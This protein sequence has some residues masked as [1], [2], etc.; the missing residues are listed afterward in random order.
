MRR[1]TSVQTIEHADGGSH[2]QVYCF[3]HLCGSAYFKKG[4]KN[5]EENLG[6]VKR[7]AEYENP[8]EQG[9]ILKLPAAVSEKTMPGSLL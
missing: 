1:I 9:R 6:I 3:G 7:L 5:Y 4:S 8:E 2:E